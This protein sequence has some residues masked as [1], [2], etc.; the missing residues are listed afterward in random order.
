VKRMDP[1]IVVDLSAIG[2]VAWMFALQ[3]SRSERK[4]CRQSGDLNS[5][6]GTSQ[7]PYATSLQRTPLVNLI[8]TSPYLI[9]SLKIPFTFT[10]TTNRFHRPV[11]ISNGSMPEAS[12]LIHGH[13][14]G[15]KLETQTARRKKALR[16]RGK[17][18]ASA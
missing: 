5:G 10:L 12:I 16:K 18:V 2:H 15:S 1:S 8:V 17:R 11:S 6:A 9:T 3:Q 13:R 4:Q 14:R 7:H